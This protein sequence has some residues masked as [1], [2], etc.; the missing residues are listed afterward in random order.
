[1]TT[2]PE[3]VLVTG[4]AGFIGFHLSQKLLKQNKQVVGLDN[5]NDYYDQGLK[6]SRLAVL[7]S[8]PGFTFHQVDLTDKQ[9]IDRLFRRILILSSAV[10][11]PQTASQKSFRVTW[12]DHPEYTLPVITE[13]WVP[14][15]FAALSA[16]DIPT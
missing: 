15:L 12:K 1:M 3:P 2:H 16:T 10:L 11:T 13:W 14:P 5:I 4:A 6:H 8:N 7:K 9:G